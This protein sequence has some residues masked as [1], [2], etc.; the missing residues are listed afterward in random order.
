[1][2]RW[3]I[4]RSSRYTSGRCA[5]AGRDR[6]AGSSLRQDK[7]FLHERS[8]H[9]ENGSVRDHLLERSLRAPRPSMAGLADEIRGSTRIP[10]TAGNGM[11]EAMT[12]HPFVWLLAFAA[13]ETLRYVPEDH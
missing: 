5:S 7:G 12:A 11:E 13:P 3:A 9:R 8:G 4:D 10:G 1:M 6:L 2:Y